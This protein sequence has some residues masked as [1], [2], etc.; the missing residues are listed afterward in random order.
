MGTCVGCFDVLQKKA[1]RTGT[2]GAHTRFLSRTPSREARGQ[3]TVLERQT[4]TC[5]TDKIRIS[6]DEARLTAAGSSPLKDL[7][8]K[9]EADGDGDGSPQ[10]R[11]LG[12]YLPVTVGQVGP[13]VALGE[14]DPVCPHRLSQLRQHP[15]RKTLTA[16]EERCVYVSTI[17][18]KE[19]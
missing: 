1:S 4:A 3:A 13:A 16:R 6:C 18:E 9:Q 19:T 14:P 17:R 5:Q 7:P 15:G 11:Q 12:E 2:G 8:E 10:I